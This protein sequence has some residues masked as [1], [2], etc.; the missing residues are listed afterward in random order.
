[1]EEK[2]NKKNKSLTKS[3][4][5]FYKSCGYLIIKNVLSNK[6]CDLF[7]EQI[8]KHAD[9]DFSAIM[10]PDRFEFLVAQSMGSMISTLP[11]NEKVHQVE[12]CKKTAEMTFQL[13]SNI[14]AVSILEELQEHEVVALMSQMLFKEAGSRYADQA[15]Q[16]HQDNVYVQ[17]NSKNHNGHT[18]Q[19]VTTNFFLSDA[20]KTNGGLYV[21]SGSH[22]FGLFDADKK[23]SY[24]ESDGSP[25]NKI[26]DSFLKKFEK[27]ECSFK[28]G[29]LLVL[30][31]NCVHGSHSNLS[32]RSRPLLSVSYITKGESFIPGKN[33]NRKV[34]NLKQGNNKLKKN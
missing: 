10:N 19:Y 5:D 25:G 18:T 2:V 9:E 23:I 6:T 22:K 34:I 29:D 28:K 7:L 13:M 3:E 16:P 27:I 21:Y 24:R 1:M 31:G 20:D 14:T 15:W 17:N 4:K 12:E 26:S 11:L 8:K 30:N 33:A 32:N